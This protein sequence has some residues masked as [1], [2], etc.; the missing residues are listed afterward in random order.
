MRATFRASNQSQ[1]LLVNA[2]GDPLNGAH[3]PY[4]RFRLI[5]SGPSP[6]CS[7]P[8]KLPRAVGSAHGGICKLSGAVGGGFSKKRV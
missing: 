4:F 7:S 2:D 3:D 5:K 8:S 6:S 1:T